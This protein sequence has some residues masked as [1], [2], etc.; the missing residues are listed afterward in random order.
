[1]NPSSKRKRLA[2]QRRELAEDRRKAVGWRLLVAHGS[3]TEAEEASADSAEGNARWVTHLPGTIDD[4]FLEAIVGVKIAR[5]MRL[6]PMRSLLALIQQRN[7]VHDDFRRAQEELLCLGMLE[8][9]REVIKRCPEPL[10]IAL[11]GRRSGMVYDGIPSP[12]EYWRRAIE[13]PKFDWPKVECTWIGEDT[14][15]QE[16]GPTP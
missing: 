13:E 1:M 10:L 4:M 8:A 14:C 9:E 3:M 12:G 7:Q 11:Q 2:Q 6:E 5:V 15:A 16:P